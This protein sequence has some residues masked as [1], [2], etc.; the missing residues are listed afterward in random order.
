MFCAF[1]FGCKKFIKRM[2]GLAL[3]PDRI[4]RFFQQLI[5]LFRVFYHRI[6][7]GTGNLPQ[8]KTIRCIF[9]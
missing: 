2:T 9:F 6:M 3:R 7:T 4:D 1:E 5:K 8:L